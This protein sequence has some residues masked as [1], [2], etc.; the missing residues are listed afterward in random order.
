MVRVWRIVDDDGGG[1]GSGK[2]RQA[3]PSEP[4]R[5][6]LEDDVHSD[7]NLPRESR[8]ED[9]MPHVLFKL[10]PELRISLIAS[11]IV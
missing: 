6:L 3:K 9:R 2:V 5:E 10:A 1:S 11:L 7:G 8:I 4:D